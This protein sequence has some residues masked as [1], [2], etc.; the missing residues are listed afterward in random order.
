MAVRIEEDSIYPVGPK[1]T[2]ISQS[3]HWAWGRRLLGAHISSGMRTFK[4][5]TKGGGPPSDTAGSDGPEASD[6][7]TLGPA[8]LLGCHKFEDSGH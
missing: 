4:K 8:D 6:Y 1:A 2:K 5:T 7:L 3:R